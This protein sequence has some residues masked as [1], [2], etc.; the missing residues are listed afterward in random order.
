MQT[1]AHSERT[2]RA[3]ALVGTPRGIA[4]SFSTT[5]ISATSRGTP[6]TIFKRKSLLDLAKSQSDQQSAVNPPKSILRRPDSPSK[7]SRARFFSPAGF[8]GRKA[9]AMDESAEILERADVRKFVASEAPA[10]LHFGV[11]TSEES[12]FSE[13]SPV[14][15]TVPAASEED[16][17]RSSLPA[18]AAPVDV[19]EE[20]EEAG[21]S[22]FATFNTPQV[23]ASKMQPRFTIPPPSP[24]PS[25]PSRS[26]RRTLQPPNATLAPSVSEVETTSLS[27]VTSLDFSTIL[28]QDHRPAASPATGGDLS[29]LMDEGGSFLLANT[30]YGSDFVNSSPDKSS[31]SGGSR[32][33]GSGGEEGGVTRLL[34]AARRQSVL[35]RFEEQTKPE[36]RRDLDTTAEEEPKVESKSGDD[37]TG[38]FKALAKKVYSEKEGK[39]GDM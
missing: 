29:C 27:N 31:A 25:S 11:D 6:S 4:K 19:H 8:G 14:D 23:A 33:S 35:K 21:S 30:T 24:N 22:P 20:P 32:R 37:S 12:L 1:F 7:P 36:G 9:A 15:E 10:R 16:L 2:E 17:L 28:D 39:T 38:D 34:S 5:A 13:V 18:S 3:S 26:A